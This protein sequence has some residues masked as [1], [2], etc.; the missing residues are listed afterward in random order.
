MRIDTET[1]FFTPSYS[2]YVRSRE[3]PPRFEDS[4]RGVRAWDEPSMPDFMH[5]RG[6]KL[7]VA[8][9]E[10]GDERVAKMDAAGIDIQVL[11]LSTPGCE[12][13][14]AVDGDREA[15][16]SN[17]E[18][19]EFIATRPD[20]FVG[21][22]A[23]APSLDHPEWAA[24]ELERCV[25]DLGF[26]GAKINSHIHDTFLDDEGYLPL[27]EAAAGLGVPLNI[28]PAVP[29]RRVA[30]PYLGYGF[31]LVGPSL[32]FGAETALCSMRLIHSGVFDRF[33]DLQ[34]V[35]GH[36]GEALAFWTYRLDFSATKPWVDLENQ[37]RLKKRPSEYLKDNF[38][39][40]TSGNFSLSAAL[41]VLVELGTDRMMLASDYPY[42][43]MEHAVDFVEGLPISP[44][45]IARV[46]SGTAANLFK[47]DVG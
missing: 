5:E 17:D 42:E 23:L 1:H 36:L 20:R 30:E 44:S 45:D 28:H 38:Y 27:M 46:N 8:L 7:E 34:I 12:Q 18:L 24:R 29:H 2:K 16:R 39:F 26:R 32:G 21:L 47:I 11:S 33:P 19:A 10:M 40:N 9:Q 22:A 31:A 13:F 6:A 43:V 15:K 14:I 35:L 37:R 3:V 4:E 41:P 25:N